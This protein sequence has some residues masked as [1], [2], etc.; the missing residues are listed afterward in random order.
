MLASSNEQQL[1]WPNDTAELKEQMRE[2]IRLGYYVL[3]K[4]EYHI[5]IYEINYFPTKGTITIDPHERYKHKGFEALL[6]LLE[7][8]H[9]RKNV[10]CM[11][12]GSR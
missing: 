1:F 4:T 12:R 6:E 9:P 5:K 7:E 8:R 2:F 3:R 11:P 10:V